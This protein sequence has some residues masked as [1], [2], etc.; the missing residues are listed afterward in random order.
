ML[1]RL[2]QRSEMIE[3]LALAG[4]IIS[5]YHR[6]SFL[7]PAVLHR[8]S[9]RPH[10]RLGVGPRVPLPL[11]QPRGALP[12][13]NGVS[14]AGFLPRYPASLTS[15]PHR[16]GCHY[17]V[18]FSRFPTH[19]RQTRPPWCRPP[20]Y[21][22]SPRK[23]ERE[24]RSRT[25]FPPLPRQEFKARKGHRISLAFRSARARIFER[26]NPRAGSR[27]NDS[28]V[29]L[30]EKIFPAIIGKLVS[31]VLNVVYLFQA[32]IVRRRGRLRDTDT[33]IRI[34]E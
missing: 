8:A 33:R 32:S 14:N 21:R 9:A 15:H 7:P 13:R 27:D 11:P 18:Q 5:S 6:R 34:F 12:P 26:L 19:E 10:L 17:A 3:E 2:K 24:T 23:R 25:K 16:A 20:F 1:P 4:I 30:V 28:N 31:K 29:S 22:F